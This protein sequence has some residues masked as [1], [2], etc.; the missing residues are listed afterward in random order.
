[1]GAFAFFEAGKTKPNQKFWFQ[2]KK[3]KI[4]KKEVEIEPQWENEWTNKGIYDLFADLLWKS[5][6][7]LGFRF[8]IRNIRFLKK[9]GFSFLTQMAPQTDITGE[10]H[11]S[12]HYWL[13][14]FL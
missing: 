4:M 8:S 7:Y 6:V 9:L 11:V 13:D 12:K 10:R 2:I 5:R 3:E 1:M 14:F